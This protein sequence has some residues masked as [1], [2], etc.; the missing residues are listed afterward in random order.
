VRAVF[1]HVVSDPIGSAGVL[2]AGALT[3]FTGWWRADPA[4]SIFIGCLVL[5]NS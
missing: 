3:F 4:V 2:A 5:L 1:V